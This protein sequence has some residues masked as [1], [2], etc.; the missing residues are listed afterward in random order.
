MKSI[1]LQEQKKYSIQ[2]LSNKFECSQSDF[3]EIFKKLL[4]LGILKKDKANVELISDTVFSEMNNFKT[5]AF[6]YDKNGQYVLT[7]VGI[8]IVNNVLI[9]CYPKYITKKEKPIDE[10]YQILNVIRKYNSESQKIYAF[11]DAD[12]DPFNNH[13]QILLSLLQDYFENGIYQHVVSIVE[14]NGMGEICWNKTINEI[15]PLILNNEPYYIDTY[16]KKNSL[17]KMYYFKELHECIL[18]LAS[19]ELKE[20]GLLDIFQITE[21][22]LTDKTLIEFGDNDIILSRIDNERSIEFNTR[23]LRVLK[24]MHDYI[25]LKS[26]IE[27]S[28]FVSIYGTKNFSHLWEVLCSKV[29]DNQLYRPLRDLRLPKLLN[30]NYTRNQPLIKIIEKPLWTFT[31]MHANYTLIP[32]I[33]AINGDEFCII[34]AKY[35]TPK[36]VPGE[37]PKRQPGVEDIVKQYMYQLF[38]NEF[39]NEHGFKKVN[40][41]FLM[42][43]ENEA[44]ECRGEACL[45]ILTSLKLNNIQVRM[46]PAK[47]VYDFYLKEKK[48]DIRYLELY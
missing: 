5:L 45:E 20:T 21:V 16:T 19:T 28:N 27:A 26:N 35:Y 40:N 43:T 6:E 23:K 25:K 46:I 39:V 48:F 1:Y 4:N 31:K 33:V 41:C 3:S 29:M 22:N 7:F 12:E 13:V 37:L 44:V 32:D 9:N 11:G 36:L 38:F 24:M 10:L 17:D 14:M 18:T 30:P 34:D 8:I 15:Q 2:H 47:Q 42:P